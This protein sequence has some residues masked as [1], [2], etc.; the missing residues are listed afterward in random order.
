MMEVGDSTTLSKDAARVNI[1]R[2]RLRKVTAATHYN[3]AALYAL[4]NKAD[5]SLDELRSAITHG[6]SDSQVLKSDPDLKN[7]RQLPAFKEV[8]ALIR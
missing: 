3:L 8:V 2:E 6:F 1:Y 4:Q 7:V 5:A